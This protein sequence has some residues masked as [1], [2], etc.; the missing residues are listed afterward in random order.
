[1]C[2]WGLGSNVVGGGTKKVEH[3]EGELLSDRSRRRARVQGSSRERVAPVC[4]SV[5]AS[6]GRIR[7]SRWPW[8]RTGRVGCSSGGG[9]EGRRRIQRNDELWVRS[10]GPPTAT[11]TVA[12]WHSLGS[13]NVVTGRHAPPLRVAPHVGSRGSRQRRRAGRHDGGRRE[14]RK[15]GEQGFFPDRTG[16]TANRPKLDEFKFQIKINRNRFGPV[17]RQVRP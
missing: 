11:R 6:L 13:C 14:G 1:M 8:R 10:A 17:H 2:S 12:Q 9:G 3:I 5:V 16:S 7:A 15:G 4:R